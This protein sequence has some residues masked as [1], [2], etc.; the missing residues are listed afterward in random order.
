VSERL[1]HPGSDPLFIG[2]GG[3]ETT[4]IFDEGFEL[5][6]SRRSSCCVSRVASTHCV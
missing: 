5:R 1:P 6:P 4:M 3:L 2:D